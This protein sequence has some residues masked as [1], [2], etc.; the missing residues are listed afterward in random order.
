MNK[1]Q[2][3][4]SYLHTNYLLE[5]LRV[6]VLYMTLL[7]LTHILITVAYRV[8]CHRDWIDGIAAGECLSVESADSIQGEG[9]AADE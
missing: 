8:G 3:L 7:V 2:G 1:L 6:R 5:V 4:Y 9:G